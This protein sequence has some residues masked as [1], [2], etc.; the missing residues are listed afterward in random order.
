MMPADNVLPRLDAV[1]DFGRGRGV[2]RCPAHDDKSPSLTWTVKDDG[3][4]LLHCWA[5]CTNY[6]VVDAIGLKLRD[7]FVGGHIDRRQLEHR[8]DY[9]QACSVLPLEA[10]VVM[11]AA[12]HIQNGIALTP[13][14][15]E[16]VQV[17]ANRIRD[18][19][20]ATRMRR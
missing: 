12:D 3:T 7:L 17:A 1:R 15:V 8:I 18:A 6:D 19:V 2:A 14:D 11:L 20:D 10:T 13:E 9:K 5:G 4:L 16:R